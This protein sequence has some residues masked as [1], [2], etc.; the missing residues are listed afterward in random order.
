MPTSRLSLSWCSPE[1][2]SSPIAI[3]ESGELWSLGYFVNTY[4]MV[5]MVTIYEKHSS[6]DKKR[7]NVGD[8]SVVKPNGITPHDKITAISI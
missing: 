1:G 5:V 4:A 8:F 6:G 7:K 2:G 3:L